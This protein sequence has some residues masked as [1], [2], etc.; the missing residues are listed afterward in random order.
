MVSECNSNDLD[1]GVFV[2]LTID[3]KC[4]MCRVRA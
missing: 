1:R 3:G 4:E 2:L